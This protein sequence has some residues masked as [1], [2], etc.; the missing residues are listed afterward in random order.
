[1]AADAIA[2]EVAEGSRLGVRATRDDR[3]R[4]A[5]GE[6]GRVFERGRELERAHAEDGRSCRL[7]ARLVARAAVEACGHLVKKGIPAFV[8]KVHGHFPP[9]SFEKL[10]VLPVVRPDVRGILPAIAPAKNEPR[11][12]GG[13][14]VGVESKTEG[15][16]ED[17]PDG[18]FPGRAGWFDNRPLRDEQRAELVG[19]I[20][21]VPATIEGDHDLQTT[22]LPSW[23]ADLFVRQATTLRT[24][25]STPRFPDRDDRDRPV[26]RDHPRAEPP[27]IPGRRQ[28]RPRA[29]APYPGTLRS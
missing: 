29:P 27:P 25:A 22:Q 26:G 8:A 10:R 7:L 15:L 21:I 5:F 23:P 24:R 18:K 11:L 9:V 14:V 1:M 28:R 13:R 20:V 16:G 2:D 6:E 17:R 3:E 19:P 4:R 12:D